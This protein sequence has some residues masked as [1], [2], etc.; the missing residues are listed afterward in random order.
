[1]Y[2]V[3][4]RPRYWEPGFDTAHLVVPVLIAGVA[5]LIALLPSQLAAPLR[6]APPTPV[7]IVP[8]TILSPV[9]G[10]AMSLG[11]SVTVDGVAQ[12][13][14]IVRL[15]W[16]AQPVG[17]PTRVAP[18]GRWHFTLGN[19]PAG[20]HSIRVGAW[21][22]GRNLWSPEVVFTATNPAPA[23]T[24]PAAKTTAKPVPSKKP[25]AKPPTKKH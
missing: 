4:R 13:G 18:D 1:M 2:F 8:T 21:V 10:M 25:A 5:L 3:Q 24:S 19:L 15:Y 9:A 12:P 20:T 14:S 17:E 23:V 6:T 22:A 11:Q 16:Y 7:N